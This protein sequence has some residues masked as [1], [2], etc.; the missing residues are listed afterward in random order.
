MKVVLQKDVSNLGDAGE[1][2][3]VANGYARNYLFPNKL[4]LRA[5][6]G[7]AK[8]AAHQKKLIELKKE[9]RKKAM[10]DVSAELQGKSFEITVK[11]GKND[12]LFGSVTSMDISNL[13]KQ[14]GYEIEKRKIDIPEVIKSLGTFKVRLKLVEGVQPIIDIKVIKEKQEE[15]ATPVVEETVQEATTETPQEEPEAN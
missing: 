5:N 2:K 11:T 3:E 1:I 10:K 13:L 4:A 9:K 7:N 8:V 15:E 6:D 12:R 14:N